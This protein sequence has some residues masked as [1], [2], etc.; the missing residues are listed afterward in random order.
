[1]YYVETEKGMLVGLFEKLIGSW[2]VP[3]AEHDREMARLNSLIAQKEE[4]LREMRG[5]VEKA[6]HAASLVEGA[7]PEQLEVLKAMTE[8]YLDQ[9]A[10]PH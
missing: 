4:E 8:Q 3:R 9:Q 5:I 1:V 6:L 2:L 7:S 10:K